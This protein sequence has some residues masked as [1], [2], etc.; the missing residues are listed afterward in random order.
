[1]TKD[2][3]FGRAVAGGSLDSYAFSAITRE[4]QQP[5][6]PL[7]L[8]A[9]FPKGETLLNPD[10]IGILKGAP[11]R[12][13]A[14]LFVEYNLSED[15][16]QRLWMLQPNTLPGSPRR[17]SICRLSI[18]PALY[19]E[20]NYPPSIRSVPVNPFD[21]SQVG[22]LVDFSNKL[23][24]GRRFVMSDLFGC[25]IIDTHDELNAAW[26]AV[27]SSRP[28]GR[29]DDPLEE[30]LFAPPCSQN[31]VQALTAELRKGPVQRAELLSRW[32]NEARSRY[33]TIRQEAEAR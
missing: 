28:A 17:Y 3:V 12:E 20:A 11:H 23:A 2:V 5:G 15:G 4:Q 22:K 33:R 31:E 27:L 32:L 24:D 1:V 29:S 30:R 18:M 9:V 7:A 25:W 8:H 14:Q 21:E 19:V 13:L 10:S 6:Y 16:G 26:R